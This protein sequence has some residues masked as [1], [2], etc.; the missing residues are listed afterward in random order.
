MSFGVSLGFLLRV[1]YGFIEGSFRVLF[2]F[3]FWVFVGFLFGFLEGFL[4]VPFKVFF[5]LGCSLGFLFHLPG[6]GC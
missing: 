2:R 4:R 6:E 5:G 1:P 3:S